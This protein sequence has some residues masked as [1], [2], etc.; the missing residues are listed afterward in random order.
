MKLEKDSNEGIK[1][2]VREKVNCELKEEFNFIITDQSTDKL[3]L[4]YKNESDKNKT[5]CK[6][7][8]PLNDLQQGITKEI[9]QRMESCG[10]IHLYLQINKSNEEPFQDTKFIS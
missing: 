8:I 7:V 5:L 2:I 4:E 9:K 10:I 1:S 3:I 6:C